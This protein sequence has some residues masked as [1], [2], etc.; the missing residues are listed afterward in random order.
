MIPHGEG[1]GGIKSVANAF[2][3]IECIRD[4]DEAS[5]KRIADEVGLASST[6]HEYLSTL[7]AE[8]YVVKRDGAYR[9]S[10][11]FL[12]CG[13][14]AQENYE[15]IEAASE[16]LE[17]LAAESG[18]LSWL[19]VEE[20]GYGAYLDVVGGE[21]AVNLSV[22]VG[23]YAPLNQLA[24]GKAILAHLPEERVDEMIDRRGVPSATERTIADSESLFAELGVVRE[25]GYAIADEERR[26]GIRGVASPV[27]RDGRAVGAIGVSG[28]SYRLTDG[29]LRNRLVDAVET[30]ANGTEF[31]LTAER[32]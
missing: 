17:T 3:I 11:R 14:H 9:L 20:N 1:G 24:A 27:L 10:L 6:A 18:E 26:G 16:P 19:V 8:G 30:A 31:W 2:E 13:K 25:R 32:D 12:S 29:R 7:L 4:A 21:T 23:D 22:R 5:L 28:P 15:L